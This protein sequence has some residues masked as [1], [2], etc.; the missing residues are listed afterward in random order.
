[1]QRDVSIGTSVR[2]SKTS[3]NSKSVVARLVWTPKALTRPLEP[4]PDPGPAAEEALADRSPAVGHPPC[5]AY[6][7]ASAFHRFETFF[8]LRLVISD[9]SSH[10]FSKVTVGL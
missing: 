4:K 8:C 9:Q 7:S 10:V 5:G 3:D 1:M 6:P 2:T